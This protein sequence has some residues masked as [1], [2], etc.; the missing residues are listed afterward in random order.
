M[1]LLQLGTFRPSLQLKIL[2]SMIVKKNENDDSETSTPVPSKQPP[3]KPAV[4]PYKDRLESIE[5]LKHTLHINSTVELLQ[6]LHVS[7]DDIPFWSDIDRLYGPDF[8]HILGLDRCQDYRNANP[9]LKDRWIG[10]A[11]L[12]HTGTNLL[13]NILPFV[14]D[15]IPKNW[16]VP[17]GKHH[18]IRSVLEDNYIIP[19]PEYEKVGNFS[20]ILPVVMVRNPLDWMVSECQQ[21]FGIKVNMNQ[22]QTEKKQRLPCPHLTTPIDVNFYRPHHYDSM[23]HLWMEWNQ[24][25]IEYDGPRL[26]VRLEDMVYH[27]Q[28]T[29]E[30]ICDCAGGTFNYSHQALERRKGGIK[31]KETGDYRFNAWKKHAQVS[32]T[33]RLGKSSGNQRAFRRL[34]ATD[35]MQ[36]LLNAFHY[37]ILDDDTH[38]STAVK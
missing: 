36:R 27:P 31:R 34:A 33:S 3:K 9:L 30:Q 25:Y 38:N 37:T 20:R 14:C 13:G 12:F 4:S 28:E 7:K 6:K 29:F 11:G 19:K 18:P 26:M 35:E 15:G 8:P 2:P 22:T 23:L 1:I 24:Q 32:V 5:R 16:Q 21:R 17:Y 10:A